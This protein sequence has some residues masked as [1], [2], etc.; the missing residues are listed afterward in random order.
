[1]TLEAKLSGEAMVTNMGKEGEEVKRREMYI[2]KWAC[3]I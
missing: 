1:M 2:Y 3:T